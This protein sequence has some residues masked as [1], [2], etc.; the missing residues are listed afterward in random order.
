M[1][2]ETA[3]PDCR[4]AP[5][6]TLQR[7]AAW[8]PREAAEALRIALTAIAA[9]WLAMWLELALPHWAGWTVISVTLATRAA[10]LR[11]SL[12]RAG[13]T[14]VGVTVAMVLVANFAQATLA[15]DLALALDRKSVV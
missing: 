11:K 15:F 10:S 5:S 6:D 12:W 8:W 3:L 13:S 7:L 14:L 1:A 2:G 9:I 4:S